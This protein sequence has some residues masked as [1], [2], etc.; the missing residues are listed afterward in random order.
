MGCIPG[1]QEKFMRT[2][3]NSCHYFQRWKLPY[4]GRSL[5]S[6]YFSEKN[7]LYAARKNVSTQKQG[8]YQLQLLK[9]MIK[10]TSEWMKV[11]FCHRLSFLAGA[12]E[13]WGVMDVTVKQCEIRMIFILFF[14]CHCFIRISSVF[15]YKTYLLETA[16]VLT[17][18]LF[19][20]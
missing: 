3:H 19:F 7:S 12:V 9:S 16:D 14:W 13:P 1:Q 18:A 6:L 8:L 11:Y 5:V 10:T 17:K 4:F 20:P 15:N 2:L